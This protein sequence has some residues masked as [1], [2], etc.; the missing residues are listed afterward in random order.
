M[1]KQVLWI[2]G[3][4][5]LVGQNLLG[6]I[7]EE[8]Y[9]VYILSRSPKASNPKAKYIKWNT[10]LQLIETDII[11]QHIINLAGAG[12]A[13]KRWSNSRKLTL[14]NSRVKSAD[15]I[16]TYLTQNAI[17]IKTYIAASA[18][19]YY[20]NVTSNILDEQSIP[21]DEFLS[22]CCILWEAASEKIKPLTENYYCLRIGLVLSP[23]GGALP[24]MILTKKLRLFPYFGKGE[25]YYP[26]IHIDDLSRMMIHCIENIPLAGIYNAVAPEYQTN[27]SLMQIIKNETAGKW[28][29]LISAPS[30]ILRL[31]MG[32]MSSVI[33]NSNKV[34]AEK[35]LKTNFSFIYVD[36]KSALSNLLSK[37]N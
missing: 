10:D 8:K 1:T 12:I 14:V 36:A 7:D 5:G 32:E 31:I 33:L 25:Q 17:K 13:D 26:W 27:K 2:A 3:G 21:G 18:V 35:I 4:D 9:D 30:I 11:P 6:W 19:G 24:K 16:R 34:S 37:I 28:G 23:L 22:E 29:L 15:T 20:G